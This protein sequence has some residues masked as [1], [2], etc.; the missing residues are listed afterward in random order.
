M[1]LRITAQ[2]VQL[3]VWGPS[4]VSNNITFLKPR[5][6]FLWTSVNTSHQPFRAPIP[7]NS[8]KPLWPFKIP[9]VST[10]EVRELHMGQKQACVEDSFY[11]MSFHTHTLYLVWDKCIIN[12]FKMLQVLTHSEHGREQVRQRESTM[13]TC[14]EL[15]VRLPRFQAFGLSFISFGQLISPLWACFLI[16]IG[17]RT[18]LS[19][20]DV[21]E[22]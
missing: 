22:G 20:E 12:A 7:L 6:E 4:Q 5:T 1:L 21:S 11:S 13:Y 14:S 2:L 3:Q 10:I 16:S 8:Q 19:P 18:H 15:G 9:G 17:N